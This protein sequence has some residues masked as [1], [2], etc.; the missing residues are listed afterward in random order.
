MTDRTE[1]KPTPKAR[2]ARRATRGASTR[3]AVPRQHGKVDVDWLGRDLLGTWAERRL[4]AR[5]KVA[6]GPNA[7]AARLRAM[8]VR[9]TLIAGEAVFGTLG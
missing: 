8:P 4:A 3:G 6:D 9:A 5:A 1:A 2:A 7:A